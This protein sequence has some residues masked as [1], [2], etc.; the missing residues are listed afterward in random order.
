MIIGVDGTRSLYRFVAKCPVRENWMPG[1]TDS[2]FRPYQAEG[3]SRL[4]RRS[5]S[6]NRGLRPL[7]SCSLF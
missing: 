1:R 4:R 2:C 3:R 6:L 5:Q 7:L